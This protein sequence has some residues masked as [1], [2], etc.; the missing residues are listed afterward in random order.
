[1]QL[2]NITFI[3]YYYITMTKEIM[4]GD[5]AR[6]SIFNGIEMVAKTVMATMGPKGKNVLLSRDYGAPVP[7]NDGVTVAKEISF[8][9]QYHNAWASIVKEAADKTNK[10]AGDWTTTTTTLLYAIAKEGMRYINTGLN[11]FSLTKGLQ[12][13]V[14]FLTVHLKSMAQPVV[15]KKEV[16]QIATIS[17]QDAEVGKLIADIFEEVG[18]DG[19]ISVE[20]GKAMGLEKEVVIGMEFDQWYSSPYFV[21]DS[22]RMESVIENSVIL[23][24][25]HRIS[26]LASILGVLESASSRGIRNY[27]IIAE[28][29]DGEALN[30]LVV[31]KIKGNGNFLAVRAPGYGDRKKDM[32]KDIAAVVGATYIDSQLDMRLEDI[33]FEQLGAADKIIA[34]RDKTTIIGG[35]SAE[36]AIEDRVGEITNQLAIATTDYDKY[37]LTQRKARLTGGVAVIRVGAATE[38]EMKNKKYKI[39][40]ALNATRAAVEEGVVAGGGVSLAVL[41]NI[42]KEMELV[43]DAD[44]Y[45]GVKILIEAMTYPMKVIADNAGYKGDYVVGRV[46]Q[47]NQLNSCYGFDAKTGIYG[48]MLTLGIID[49]TKV[50]RVALENAVSAAS[51]FLTTE[52]I[53]VELPQA[54]EP[55]NIPQMP[56]MP[57]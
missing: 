26:T 29:I 43:W 51:M 3:F 25:D 22:T 7:T 4:Y 15:D 54:Q 56:Q 41:A 55:I 16:E 53:I 2:D 47:E 52:A 5:Q 27:V 1:M 34:T 32:L 46:L 13:A 48:D 39:E 45:I 23:V 35:K 49:P 33:T 20:E 10:Q 8:D 24:T 42:L 12:Q 6:K 21:T 19:V 30:S 37:N 50:I 28:E 31:N 40:D 36:G 17:A 9:N 14:E 44:A 38:M 57:Y 11:P 18:R